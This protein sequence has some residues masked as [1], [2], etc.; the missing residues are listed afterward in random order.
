MTA[1]RV[2]RRAMVLEQVETEEGE[3]R[4]QVIEDAGLEI[5]IFDKGCL[6]RERVDFDGKALRRRLQ[7]ARKEVH[8]LLDAGEAPE[9]FAAV[10]AEGFEVREPRRLFFCGFAEAFRERIAGNHILLEPGL[11]FFGAFFGKEMN[12]RYIDEE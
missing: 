7:N 3:R 8:V 12:R 10:D 4:Y 9:V 11:Q 2:V 5:L 6:V 1:L